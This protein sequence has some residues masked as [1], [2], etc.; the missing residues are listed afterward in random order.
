MAN[1]DFLDIPRVAST[2]R[3]K[4]ER[5]KDFAEVEVQPSID[6]LKEQ[7]RRCMSCGIPFCHGM[8]CPLKN[9]IPEINLAVA[10]GRFEDAWNLLSSTSSFPEF[11]SRICPAL[12]EGSCTEGLDLEAVTIRQL[13]HLVTEQA[14]ARG[15]VKPQVPAH[16]T[17]KGVAVIGGGP[18]GLA[19]AARLNSY[20]HSVTVLE[21]NA[22]AGGLLRYGIP[23]FKLDKKVIDRRVE[24]MEKSGIAFKYNTRV[25]I[26][27][28]FDSMKKEFDA[29]VF[30]VG[31]PVYRDLPVEGRE[32][33]GIYPALDYLTRQNRLVSNEPY[34]GIEIDAKGKHVVVIGGGDTGSD[35]VGTAN[36][37][38][39]ASVTQI[40]IMPMPPEARSESTPWPQWPY[41][42][43]TSSSHKEGCSRDWNVATKFF[44]GEDGKVKELHA[45]RVEW[46]FS[47]EGKPLRFTEVPNS[48][49]VLKA[50]L[51]M[52]AL[53]FVGFDSA[54]VA[55]RFGFELTERNW[56]KADATGAT[57]LDGVFVSGDAVTGPS[58]VVRCIA[59][60]RSVAD[61]VD[62]Y[63][64]G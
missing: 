37:Q 1:R 16:R 36:R 64:K 53:G 12:C 23:D 9:D 2:Y 11:T 30:A 21:A 33:E 61:S 60:G 59:N 4:E 15:L 46:E 52:L 25:G 27:V 19:V 13:E 55:E 51:V 40:E 58:L 34:D 63:L 41:L 50:D 62:T 20:G 49:F 44:A 47:P 39:A 43:R 28:T 24:I 54:K 18:A 17:G 48:E 45:V 35:C 31:T 10:E 14:F 38:G 26:D 6:T 5:L 7:A 32:L 8:G 56:V 57:T 42:L 22:K 3:D 29:M